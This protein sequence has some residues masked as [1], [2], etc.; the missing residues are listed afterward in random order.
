MKRKCFWLS[1]LLFS[2][3]SGALFA[4]AQEGGKGGIYEVVYPLGRSNLKVLPLAPHIPDLR[5]KTICGSGHS[6]NGDE[7][8]AEVAKLLQERYPGLKHVP[9]SEIPDEVATR[10]EIAKLKEVLKKKGCDA[11]ISSTGC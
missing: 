8:V 4:L 7:V 1:F 3:L 11:V 2:I 5:G 10:E 6:F 9:N